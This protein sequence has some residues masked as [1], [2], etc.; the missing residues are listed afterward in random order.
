M[1]HALMYLYVDPSYAKAGEGGLQGLMLNLY[2]INN[3][4]NNN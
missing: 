3:N 2:I 1:L 4:N